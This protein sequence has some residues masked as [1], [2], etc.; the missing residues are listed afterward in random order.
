MTASI[1]SRSA[2]FQENIAL[3]FKLNALT[4][5]VPWQHTYFNLVGIFWPFWQLPH[6][7]ELNLLYW[8]SGSRSSQP[9]VFCKKGALRNFAKST[10]KHL[11]QSFFFNKVFKKE[12]L[13]QVFYSEFCEIFK[14]TSSGC[15]CGSS[16][17]LPSL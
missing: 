3:L 9:D 12:T 4:S 8:V 11:Y 10:G 7:W 13:T 2:I 14:N 1:N 16:W 5:G 15:F 17:S 6:S